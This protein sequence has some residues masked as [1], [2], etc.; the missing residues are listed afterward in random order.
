MPP[1][2]LPP[3]CV[4]ILCFTRAVGFLEG[5]LEMDLNGRNWIPE[6]IPHHS[7]R[8]AHYLLPSWSNMLLSRLPS[9]SLPLLRMP[10]D[11]EG[12]GGQGIHHIWTHQS[13][14][15]S[16]DTKLCSLTRASEGPRWWGE[17]KAAVC[18]HVLLQ[19][20]VKQYI[21][22]P[23]FSG[24]FCSPM[25]KSFIT[26]LPMNVSFRSFRFHS[27]C[28]NAHLLCHTSEILGAICQ[29]HSY[30]IRHKHL[31]AS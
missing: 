3:T 2:R 17:M 31:C 6:H 15:S 4:G 1:G 18:I 20:I 30:A 29:R 12:A 28:C 25:I 26:M 14:C 22:T 9:S 11:G 10:G 8:L 16:R 13:S 5:H 23:A 24:H 21:I 7:R 19:C 27:L